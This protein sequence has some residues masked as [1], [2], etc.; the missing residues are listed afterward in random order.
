MLFYTQGLYRR[1]ILLTLSFLLKQSYV[2]R[3]LFCKGKWNGFFFHAVMFAATSIFKHF[4]LFLVGSDLLEYGQYFILI[5][6]GKYY[7][8]CTVIIQN[9]CIY[10]YTGYL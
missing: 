5:D 6:V 3:S 1:M 10:M 2:I 9:T 7:L 4:F 8:N